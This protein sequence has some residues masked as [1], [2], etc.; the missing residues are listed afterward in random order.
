MA[1][2]RLRAAYY[3]T[4]TFSSPTWVLMSRISDVSRSRSRPTSDRKYRGAKVG[5]KI[6]GYLEY[7]WSFKYACKKAGATDTVLDALED[8]FQNE[9]VMDVAFLNGIIASGTTRK[10]E[11]APVV[12][13]KL[14]I[15][16]SDEEGVT[17]DVELSH[18]EDEQSG[19]LNEVTAL[20]VTT[21]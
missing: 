15:N 3:N 10:G 21:S 17:Y 12:V 11:R 20:T 19:S 2:G 9:T 16:E 14:D 1:A 5:K 4:G 6:T 7:S 13:T 8:S 18:V